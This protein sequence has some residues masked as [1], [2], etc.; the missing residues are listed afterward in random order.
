M[1]RFFPYNGASARERVGTRHCREYI[2]PSCEI[3]QVK[4]ENIRIGDR[5]FPKYEL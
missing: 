2:L 4:S 5:V 3:S 1:I